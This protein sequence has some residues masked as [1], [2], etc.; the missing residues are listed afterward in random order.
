M[1]HYKYF[2]TIVPMSLILTLI[3]LFPQQNILL[4]YHSKILLTQLYYAHHPHS[5]NLTANVWAIIVNLSDS[6]DW[7]YMVFVNIS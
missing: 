6:I 7:Y 5:I 1:Y 3:L 4:L 2:H